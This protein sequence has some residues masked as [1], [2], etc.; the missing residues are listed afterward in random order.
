LAKFEHLLLGYWDV[1]DDLI[2]LSLRAISS[3][4]RMDEGQATEYDPDESLETDFHSPSF[5]ADESKAKVNPVASIARLVLEQMKDL[6][7]AKK[8]RAATTHDE[9][10]Q[11]REE[12][13]LRRAIIW[14]R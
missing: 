1:K 8:K 5:L 10:D 11:R 7:A 13:K 2:M 12:A 14:R 3:Y 9:V 6:H 4:Q